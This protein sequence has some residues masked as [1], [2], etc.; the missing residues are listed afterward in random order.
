MNSL[1]H[2]AR[3][4]PAAPGRRR[5]L[6]LGHRASRGVYAAVWSLPLALWQTLFFVLPL[7]FLLV[8]TFWVVQNYRLQPDF[9]LV[10][11]IDVLGGASFWKTYFRTVALALGSA[12]VATVIA[13]P[14]AYALAF[15]VS[16]AVRRLG[17]LLLVTP[18]FTSYLVRVYSWMSI[19]S[20]HGALN[21]VLKSLGV[22]AISVL[23]SAAGTLVGYLTLCLPLAILI[24]LMSLANVDRSLIEAAHN[25]R[26]PRWRTV[27]S[28][29][30]PSARVGIV[31]AAVF[32]FILS[33]GDF[34]SPTYLGGGNPPT[35]SILITD[36]TKSGQQWPR[37]AVVAIT[38]IVTLLAAVSLALGFAYRGRGVR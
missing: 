25:L 9:S 33:F 29:I 32:T 34:V 8:L 5:R 14:C 17:V 30:I 12:L 36:F 4:L 21:A 20:D 31:V 2:S 26:C 11:W 27:F 16:P 18:F 19:L 10:N 7:G 28:V 22:G 6:V 38:M 23:N 35:L 13:F 37:A 24:Q 3:A 1:P 15:T